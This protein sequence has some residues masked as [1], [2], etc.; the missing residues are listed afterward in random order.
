MLNGSV[1]GNR[2]KDDSYVERDQNGA[3]KADSIGI[4]KTVR[5]QDCYH[6]LDDHPLQI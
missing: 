5:Q 3:V 1:G 4:T 6:L 2:P